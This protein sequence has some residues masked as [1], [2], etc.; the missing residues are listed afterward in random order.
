MRVRTVIMSLKQKSSETA[1]VKCSPQGH[2]PINIAR[3]TG[4]LK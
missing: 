1:V 2:S 4:K 3:L